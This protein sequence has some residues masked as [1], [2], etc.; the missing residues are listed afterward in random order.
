[1]KKNF[2]IIATLAGLSTIASAASKSPD[3]EVFVLP[4]Y[5]VTAPRF[6]SAEQ[7]IRT[8]LNELRHQPLLAKAITPDFSALRQHVAPATRVAHAPANV[9]AKSTAKS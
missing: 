8:S 3:S 7:Q 6:E 4:T 5:V 2:L 9:T 1:M